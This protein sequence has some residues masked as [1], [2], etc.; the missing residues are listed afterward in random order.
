MMVEDQLPR[1]VVTL[2]TS[3]ADDVLD[4]IITSSHI[5]SDVIT[6]IHT[7]CWATALDNTSLAVPY[8]TASQLERRRERL[9]RLYGRV[10]RRIDLTQAD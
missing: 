9:N 5:I 4:I 1:G 10:T 7:D 6:R 3:P 2:K 8:D